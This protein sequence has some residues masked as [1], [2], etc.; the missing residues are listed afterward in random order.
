[1]EY[2]YK[3]VLNQKSRKLLR[4]FASSKY[5]GMTFKSVRSLYKVMTLEEWIEKYNSLT[6]R[7]QARDRFGHS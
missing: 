2:T 4:E 7:V 6:G 1:M 5:P 3:G